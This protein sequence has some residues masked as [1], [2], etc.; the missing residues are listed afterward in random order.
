M[1]SAHGFLRMNIVGLNVFG[2]KH[3]LSYFW[4]ETS[5]FINKIIMNMKAPLIVKGIGYVQ[6][7]NK[8]VKI[9]LTIEN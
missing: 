2:L 6:F 5:S 9:V 7:H 1:G 8:Q 4:S 3:Y